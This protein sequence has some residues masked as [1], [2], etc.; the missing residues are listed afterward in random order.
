MRQE[1]FHVAPPLPAKFRF[2][3]DRIVLIRLIDER[4]ID[5]RVK[6]AGWCVDHEHTI[7]AVAPVVALIHAHRSPLRLYGDEIPTMSASGTVAV[8]ARSA[9][10]TS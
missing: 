6:R 5:L 8:A 10:S 1:G 4:L 9:T 7:G 2:R 3:R